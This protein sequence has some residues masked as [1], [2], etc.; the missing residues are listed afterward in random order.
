[1][2]PLP[3]T[4][5]E[6]K[7]AHLSPKSVC[8]ACSIPEGSEAQQSDRKGRDCLRAGTL[9]EMTSGWLVCVFVFHVNVLT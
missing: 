1:M 8:L 9:S 5:V 6:K 3:L 7:L 4:L 2:V